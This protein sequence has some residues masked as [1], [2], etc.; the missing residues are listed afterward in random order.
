MLV[1]TLDALGVVAACIGCFGR[2]A[3]LPPFGSMF[4]ARRTRVLRATGVI[5][6]CWCVLV[7]F[8][9]RLAR[10]TRVIA[11]RRRGQLRSGMRRARRSAVRFPR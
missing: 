6:L 9:A 7:R 11:F 3:A 1:S 2:S 4:L 8:R 5:A 10:R